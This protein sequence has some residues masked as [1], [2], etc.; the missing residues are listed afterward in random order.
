MAKLDRYEPHLGIR[1]LFVP[2]GGEWTPQLSGWTLIQVNAGSGYWMHPRLNQEINAGSVLLLAPNVQGNIRASRLGELSLYF[3][4]VEPERLTGLITLGEQRYF[5][6]ATFKDELA[7]QI[8]SPA[9]PLAEK[10]KMLC[11]D[12]NRGGSIFRLQLLQLFIEAFGSD[13]EQKALPP[14]TSQ[15]AKERLAGFLSQMPASELLCMNFSELARL[16][17]CTPRHLSRIFREVTGMSFRDKHTEL[18]LARAR[19]LLATTESK[20]VDV[21][22]ESGYQSLSLFNLVFTRRFGMSP[23]KWRQKQRDSRSS[24]RDRRK[25]VCLSI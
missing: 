4:S 13:F 23:G 18:R 11:L 19:E 14:E 15:D 22:L 6:T 21:A 3:F 24:V 2:P 1:E 10:M 7:L 20:V 8:F 17:R 5:E 16:T 25:L 9:S 12:R